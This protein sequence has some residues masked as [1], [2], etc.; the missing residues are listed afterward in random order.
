MIV[1]EGEKLHVLTRRLFD[2]DLRRHF[3]GVVK[4]VEGEL[5]RLD[6]YV[7]I[8]ESGSTTW[9][10]RPELRTRIIGLSD[11]GHIIKVIPKHVVLEDLTYKPST[12]KHLS[13]TDGK[14]FWLDI[15]E[16]SSQR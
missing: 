13:V 9:V 16:F 8:F 15:N 4:A 2:G 11:N 10:K 12:T 1:Q 14:E 6:G 5:V 7:F 3:V